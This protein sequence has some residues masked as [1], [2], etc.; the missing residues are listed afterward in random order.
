MVSDGEDLSEP[1]YQKEIAD[2]AKLI[3]ADVELVAGSNLLIE[4]LITGRWDEQF[5]V[6]EPGER[7]SMNDFFDK[8]WLDFQESK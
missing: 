7:I 1:K 8:S 2:S 4:K 3:K 6:K 5:I